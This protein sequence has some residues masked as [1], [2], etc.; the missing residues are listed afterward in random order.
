MRRG[1][2]EVAEKGKDNVGLR[3]EKMES[4]LTMSE[5]T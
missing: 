1:T 4:L 2:Y 3:G 5:A